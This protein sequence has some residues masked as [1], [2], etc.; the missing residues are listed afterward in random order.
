MISGLKIPKLTRWIFC[1]GII[2]LLLM[3]LLRLALFLSFS[4]QGNDFGDTIPSFIL[5]LRYDLRAVCIFCLLL[6]IVGSF[7]ALHPFKTRAGRK[8]ALILTT[9]A[10]F[11]VVFFYSVD[12]AHYSYLSQ[13]LNASVLN[14]LNDAGISLRMVWQTYPVIRLILLMIIGPILI[15]L[16]VKKVYNKI[17]AGKS[18]ATKKS[19]TW[20]FIIFFLLFG[21]AI[22]GRI[23]QYPLRWSDA[24]GL[25]NDYKANLSL[26]PFQSF[27]SSLKF[28]HATYDE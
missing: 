16:M 28:L 7:S 17:D 15:L 6:M 21:L 4:R 24:F 18:S 8:V 5:G 2:F 10:A 1:T 27:A 13:R 11:L 9:I 12:F 25:G 20:W 3:T 22:F 19:R 14:Y 26:N 23:G